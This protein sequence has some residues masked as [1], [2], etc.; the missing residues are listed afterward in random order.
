MC[1]PAS[2]Y[3]SPAHL[4][5]ISFSR[6]SACDYSTQ[7][8]SAGH[9]GHLDWYHHTKKWSRCRRSKPLLI[10]PE[11]RLEV[12]LIEIIPPHH[13]TGPHTPSHT[14]SSQT[15]GPLCLKQCAR[16]MRPF[17]LHH[18]QEKKLHR[19]LRNLFGF[20]KRKKHP[21]FLEEPN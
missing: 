4:Q 21:G 20:E 7:L 18:V 11:E 12:G 6:V 19:A 5:C 16:E 10:S 17:N 15:D 1:T 3:L 8:G 14:V 9:S 13:S 2:N